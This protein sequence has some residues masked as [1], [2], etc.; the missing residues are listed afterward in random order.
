MKVFEEGFKIQ[1]FE[2]L[3]RLNMISREDQETTISPK[4]M[5]VL[6]FLAERQGSV[7]SKEDLLENVW[8]DTFVG[9]GVLW[10]CISELRQAFQDDARDPEII[11]T[12]SKR[13]YRLEPRVVPI[14]KLPKDDS[15]NYF[16]VR[17]LLLLLLLLLPAS[18]SLLWFILG[19]SSITA[20]SEGHLTERPVILVSQFEN[21]T[22]EPVLDR[23]LDFAIEQYLVS[24]GSVKVASQERIEGTLRLMRRPIDSPVDED[25]ARRICLRDGAIDVLLAGRLE[26]LDSNYLMGF[27]LIDPRGDEI[28]AAS[29]RVVM[30]KAKLLGEMQELAWWVLKELETA[31]MTQER[32]RS[33]AATVDDFQQVTTDSLEALRLYSKAVRDFKLG[34]DQSQIEVLVRKA[35][36]EDPE[37]AAAHLLWAWTLR[38]LGHDENASE[39]MDRAMELRENASLPEQAFI[40]GVYHDWQ[41]EDDKARASYELVLQLQ[42]DHPWALLKLFGLDWVPPRSREFTDALVRRAE[43]LP[44]NLRVQGSSA[45]LLIHPLGQLEKARPLMERARRLIAE[46]PTLIEGPLR[47][48]WSLSVGIWEKWL[49]GDIEASIAE[50]QRVRKLLAQMSRKGFN[51]ER[52]VAFLC[53][54]FLTLGKVMAARELLER[55]ET[56]ELLLPAVLALVEEDPEILNYGFFGSNYSKKATIPLVTLELMPSSFQQFKENPGPYLRKG[57]LELVLGKIAFVEG[58]LDEAILLFEK[59]LELL[60]DSGTFYLLDFFLGSLALSEAL[61]KVG[62]LPRAAEVLENASK[63]KKETYPESSVFWII[64]QRRLAR[65]YERLGKDARARKITDK[66][67]RLLQ[68]ADRDLPPLMEFEEPVLSRVSVD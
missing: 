11:S 51:V 34:R 44:N 62:D 26:K 7:V 8:P 57:S 25:L 15:R 39:V 3:P 14:K 58:R 36:A 19:N 1:D 4:S 42:P 47:G 41:G 9:D 67:R 49:D 48:A 18:L 23:T 6:V 38:R 10:R 68:F 32:M 55:Y 27:R 13:G 40:E 54:Q 29:T 2:A 20:D 64:A 59:G 65:L 21:L 53:Y 43:S 5:D 31:Q 66:L 22:G 16:S 17:V 12:V 33:R 45:S 37:F 63:F 50:A 61:E 24:S 30:E 52:D 35:A 56:R 46:N 60:P 28:I